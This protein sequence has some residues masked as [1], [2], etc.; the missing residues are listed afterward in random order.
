MTSDEIAKILP[1]IS[2]SLGG[3]LPLLIGNPPFAVPDNCKALFAS[4][5]VLVVWLGYWVAYMFGEW[6]FLTNAP[7]VVL[8]ACSTLLMLVVLW[9]GQK[10]PVSRP[11]PDET[12]VQDKEI[13]K[14]GYFW[15]YVLAL[16]LVSVASALYAAP[17]GRVVLE[18]DFPNGKDGPASNWTI[19]ALVR[20]ENDTLIS[21]N[22][23][24][25]KYGTKCLLTTEEYGKTSEFQVVV[26]EPGR[27]TLKNWRGK[28]E[29]SYS[30]LR[31][32]K[33]QHCKVNLE[34]K[35]GVE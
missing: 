26:N 24:D 4:I 20:N 6:P 13:E 17:D 19:A 8:I 25:N 29:W 30:V 2:L 14:R 23:R 15:I 35:K 1:P 18:L 7:I 10:P 16:L 33:G 28:R 5:L 21:L 27:T 11:L 3:V 9:A 34:R 22:H 12:V 31:A 32:G